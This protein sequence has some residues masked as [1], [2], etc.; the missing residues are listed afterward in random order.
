[1]FR[2]INLRVRILVYFI[3]LAGLILA[4]ALVI[5]RLFRGYLTSNEQYLRKI[6]QEN[7]QLYYRVG[8]QLRNLV[9]DPGQ[10]QE[11]DLAQELK[12][13]GDNLALLQK[14]GPYLTGEAE[15]VSVAPIP[16][17]LQYGLSEIIAVWHETKVGAET[18]MANLNEVAKL[19]RDAGNQAGIVQASQRENARFKVKSNLNF[20]NQAIPRVA[21][22]NA[23]LLDD[24]EK[25][26]AEKQNR[27]YAWLLA[28]LGIDLALVYTGFWLINRRMLAPLPDIARAIKSLAVGNTSV[29]LPRWT[30]QDEL[31]EIMGGIGQVAN[32]LNET[33]AFAK[34]VGKGNFDQSLQV[35]GQEDALGKAL[36]AMRDDLK[37]A[38]E[39][40]KITTWTNEG[41]AKFADLLRTSTTNQEEL[42]YLVVANLVKYIGANQGSLFIVNNKNGQPVLTLAGAYAYDK[43]KYLRKE[44]PLGDGL[45]GQA[46]WE[47]STALYTNLPDQYVEITSGLGET[48]PGCLLIVPLKTNDQVYGA[49]EIAGFDKFAPHQVAF[50]V[51]LSE[52]IAVTLAAVKSNEAMRGLLEE[53]QMASEQMRAQEEEMR[54]NMEEL[55]ATQEE[56]H[57]VQRELK[58]K[59]NNLNTILNQTDTAVYSMD[60]NF[61]LLI[62]NE[63]LKRQLMRDSGREVR[64]GQNVF[65]FIPAHLQESRRQQ[66]LRV[67][68]GESFTAIE[69][70]KGLDHSDNYY[71][72][73]FSPLY[74]DARQI[75]SISVFMRNITH[76]HPIRWE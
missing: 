71:E 23:D 8:F 65:E 34:E 17:D 61:N 19:D 75:D 18:V 22:A 43:R 56:M 39:A 48:T 24:L 58:E 5:D 15:V 47:G 3:A 6:G 10:T 36:L 60:R 62:V 35:R 74:N 26:S 28:L 30:A 49:L 72:A 20:V 25:I 14:G 73:S 70:H 69:N 55:L 66:F 50:V 57:R 4:N 41:V 42:A 13:V 33:S 40:D 27:L 1:M 37:K 68:N 51:G 9:Q 54:Q 31:A 29:Q 76:L 46:A 12:R 67:F 2:Q 59:E 38:D 45:L 11:L 32:Y 64:P 53:S 21:K 44:I 52:R 7:Q 16:S 63:A